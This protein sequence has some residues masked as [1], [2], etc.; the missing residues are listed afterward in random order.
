VK[1]IWI[2][3]FSLLFSFVLFDLLITLISIKSPIEEG[4]VLVR[5]FMGFFGVYLGLALFGCF[6]MI[7]LFF[8]LSFCKLLLGNM[9]KWASIIIS[10]V[11]DVCF[12]WFVA[13]LHFVG[14]TS[15]FWLAPDLARHCLGAGLY[16]MVL[17]L[18]QAYIST[19]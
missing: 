5:A 2:Y 3:R 15:W 7:F 16:L 12:G 9:D 1:S 17:Y 18:F 19:V 4:N 14:G 11:V 10:F 8:V 13:G 6:I